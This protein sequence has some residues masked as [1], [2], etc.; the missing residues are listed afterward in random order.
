MPCTFIRLAG[1]PLRCVYCDT[2]QAIPLD[3]GS[4]KTLNVILEKLPQPQTP[5]VLVTGGE[6]LAQ[7]NCAA[8]LESLLPLYQHVQLETAGAHD[9]SKIPEQVAIILDI[10]TPGSGEVKRNRWQNMQ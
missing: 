2:P 1:C 5:I 9:I 8:L 6:P 3:S 4:E 7:R 10:K